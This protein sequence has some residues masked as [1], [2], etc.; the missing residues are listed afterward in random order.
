MSIALVP[1]SFVI[2]VFVVLKIL[3]VS[4]KIV[5][6]PPFFFFLVYAVMLMRILNEM[7]A[8]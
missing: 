7:F 3:F 6:I 1:L 5:L 4:W 8:Y 2:K